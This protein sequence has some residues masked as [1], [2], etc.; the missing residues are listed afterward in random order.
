M[1][2][3]AYYR[4]GDVAR[5]ADVSTETVRYYQR[6]G[7]LSLPVRFYGT[8]RRYNEQY[9]QRVKSI[10]RA[11]E[12]GFSLREIREILS[13]DDG[14]CT[15]IQELAKKKYLQI[16]AKRSDLAKISHVLKNL[17][18]A[19]AS[20]GPHPTQCAVLHALAGDSKTERQR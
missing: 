18:T 9:T 4:I 14:H 7:L 1:T 5:A 12:L 15:D 20:E 16:E 17:L 2:D 6:I 8:Q 10:R 3:K 11:R 13:F 19:C